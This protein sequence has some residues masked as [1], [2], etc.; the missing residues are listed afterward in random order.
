[1][2][3][4]RGCLL[5]AEPFMKDEHFKRAVVLLAEHNEEGT[6]GF[7]LN[8]PLDI[9]LR[10]VMADTGNCLLPL[11]LG[12]PVQ[13]DNL[14]FVHTL[15]HIIDESMPVSEGLWWGGNFETVKELAKRKELE[16]DQIRFFIGYSGWTNGQ[17]EEEMK[18]NSWIVT[19]AIP[20]HITLPHDKLWGTILKSMG[21]KYAEIA[22]Y[23]EDPSLN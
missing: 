22:N 14:F 15:G 3:P 16:E 9:T 5:I 12:G 8:R 11:F 21:K 4:A 17:L 18:L 2:G 1:M 10:D 23:P 19:K 13:R 20:R 7:I 6:V